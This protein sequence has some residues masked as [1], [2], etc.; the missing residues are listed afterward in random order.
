MLGG[1]A[2]PELRMNRQNAMFASGSNPSLSQFAPENHTNG[3]LTKS[4]YNSL[5]TKQTMST[6]Q[7]V[8]LNIRALIILE[9]SD[10]DL[11]FQWLL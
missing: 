8:T 2:T 5:D 1:Y 4:L 6:L 9:S 7:S 11:V 3:P 10:Q